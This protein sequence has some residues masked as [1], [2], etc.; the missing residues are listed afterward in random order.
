MR[1][2]S[3]SASKYP[4]GATSRRSAALSRRE[5]RDRLDRVLDEAHEVRR[6]DLQLDG[7]GVVPA[8]L[9][10]VGEQHLEALDLGVQQLGGAGGRRREGL[11]LVVEH[12]AGQPD[13]RER[14][15]QLV[16]DVGDEALLHLRQVGE[17]RDLALQAVGH[18]VERARQRREH[19]VA[20][21]REPLVELAGGELLAGLGGDPHRADDQPHDDDRRRRRSAAPARARRARGS[22]GRSR[23]SAARRRGC[24]RG[25]AGSPG[26]CDAQQS[27]RR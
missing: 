4:P 2:A 14:R 25:T 6:L 10:Q 26:T 13:R 21:L 20:R 22:A 3:T 17:L 12:V 18:A 8:H 7:A 1:R 23:G 11:A 24:R 15:A 9:E 5:R 16:R 19:V 27:S